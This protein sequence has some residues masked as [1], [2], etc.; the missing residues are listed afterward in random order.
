MMFVTEEAFSACVTVGVTDNDLSVCVSPF[1]SCHICCHQAWIFVTWREIL[2]VI[3]VHP[4]R[5]YP[6]T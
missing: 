4:L 3:Y 5:I 6:W 2:M 1:P